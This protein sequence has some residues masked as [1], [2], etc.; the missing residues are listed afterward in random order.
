M[1]FVRVKSFMS[2]AEACHKSLWRPGLYG[3]LVFTVP[4]NSPGSVEA[5]LAG[6]LHAACRLHV[7]SIKFELLRRI[8]STPEALRLSPAA[9]HV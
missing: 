2:V 1:Q 6:L 9:E 4:D 8:C 7:R 3:Q 5:F